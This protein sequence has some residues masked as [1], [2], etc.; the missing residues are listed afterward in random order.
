MCNMLT[1][2]HVFP[3]PHAIA[4]A[5]AKYSTLYKI[6]GTPFSGRKTELVWIQ[7]WAFIRST[8]AWPYRLKWKLNHFAMLTFSFRCVYNDCEAWWSDLQN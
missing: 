6:A 2:L 1:Q 7:P 4:V 8:K 5:T 3:E